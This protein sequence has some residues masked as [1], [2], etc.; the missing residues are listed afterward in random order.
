MILRAPRPKANYTV[1]SNAVIED[2]SLSFKARGVLIY[3]L[4]KPDDWKV[5]VKDLMS[6]GNCGR[7]SVQAALREIEAAGYLTRTT[8]RDAAGR[9]VHIQQIHDVPQK[10]E[11]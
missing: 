5:L 2:S 4:S 8:T 6:V 3:I 1:V 9:W 11:I 7:D 10:K